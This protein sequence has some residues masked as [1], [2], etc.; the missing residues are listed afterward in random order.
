MSEAREPRRSVRSRS[1][2]SGVSLAPAGP[3]S[4]FLPRARCRPR[5]SWQPVFPA[6]QRSLLSPRLHRLL[7]QLLMSIWCLVPR[8]SFAAPRTPR[9]RLGDQSGPPETYRTSALLASPNCGRMPRPIAD[10][11]LGRGFPWSRVRAGAM[12][13]A[14]HPSIGR[15]RRE[16]IL[17]CLPYRNQ[18][19]ATVRGSATRNRH[20]L[21]IRP[22]R[23][24]RGCAVGRLDA[25]AEPPRPEHHSLE[26]AGAPGIGAGRQWSARRGNI[27]GAAVQ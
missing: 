4:A 7:F 16:S 3:S 12:N 10:T 15:G 25:T 27:D 2:R 24:P 18:G 14:A 22:G 5:R 13:C 19:R 23:H 1:A 17:I 21:R 6:G 11:P 26:P 9:L 20:G 8:R